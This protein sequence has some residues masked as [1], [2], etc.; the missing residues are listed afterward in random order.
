MEKENEIFDSPR[1]WVAEHIQRYVETDGR[2]G[3]MWKNVPTLLLTT[4]GRKTGKLRRTALIYGKDGDNHIVVASRGGHPKHP[5]WYLNL[6][7][8]P[9]VDVQVSADKFTALARTAAPDEKARLWQLMVSIWPAYED[10]QAKTERE[11]PVVIL[12]SIAR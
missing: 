2:S 9:T 1:D 5:A 8:N 10:Y 7:E 6:V 11:I 12:S 4:R 3:H